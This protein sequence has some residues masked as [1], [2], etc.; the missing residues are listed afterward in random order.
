MQNLI[1][2]GK[3]NETELALLFCR[4]WNLMNSGFSWNK[5]LLSLLSVKRCGRHVHYSHSS[6][7]QQC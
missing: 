5:Y 4:E 3:G 2:I 6:S 1:L 7:E